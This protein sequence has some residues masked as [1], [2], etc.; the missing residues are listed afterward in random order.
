MKATTIARL[1]RI[2]GK[3][4]EK[5]PRP[6][7]KGNPKKPKGRSKGQGNNGHK[8]YPLAPEIIHPLE[9]H[10]KPGQ[11][12]PECGKG[13]LHIYDPGIFIK[14]TG[15]PSLTAHKH[16]TEK[17][18]CSAC[19]TIF[20]ALISGQNKKN[21]K[22]DRSALSI[23]A[24]L[25][26][27]FSMPFY[28]I[29]KLQKMFI[30]PTPRSVQWELMEE[31]A[32]HLI[33]I[34]QAMV[35]HAR[36]GDKFHIDD[37]N[38]KILEKMREKVASDLHFKNSGTKKKKARTQ[39]HTTGILADFNTYKVMLY[40]TGIKYSGE[41][42]SALLKDRESLRPIS[43][44]SDALNQNNPKDVEKIITIVRYLCLAHGRRKFDLLDKRFEKESTF[45]KEQIAIV[46]KNDQ[47][48]KENQLTGSVRLNYHQEHSKSVMD[49]LFSWC[50][51]MFAEK[52][53]E[54]NSSLGKGIQYILNH[55]SGLTKFLECADAPLDNNIL[56]S[57][58]RTPVMNRKNWLW[59]AS[60][61]GALVGDIILS[62]LKTCELCKVDAFEYLNYIQDHVDEVKIDPDKYLPWTIK[63][64]K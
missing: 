50:N 29:E 6:P 28:R 22:Y 58:L 56:E 1:R 4:S 63:I 60:E 62:V 23:I 34:W 17:S 44:M 51:R 26:Y 3:K 55:W 20:E 31:L 8:D 19:G 41:N 64:Q 30:T 9:E 15:S 32:N 42:L 21:R 43:I 16:I 49:N 57:Q 2:F 46:Y 12:C 14:I 7:K 5:L 37:T 45:I 61:T 24:M 38:N 11:P 10:L 36:E 53:V 33:H 54:P 47:Y 18:R 39:V 13:T 52:L 35:K 27:L 48:C 25:H 59:Y 40:F